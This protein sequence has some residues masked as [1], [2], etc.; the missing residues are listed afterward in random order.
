VRM[1]IGSSITVMLAV[2]S[3]LAIASVL[4]VIFSLSFSARA[5][6][7]SDDCERIKRDAQMFLDWID[8][9]NGENDRLNERIKDSQERFAKFQASHDEILDYMKGNPLFNKEEARARYLEAKRK[10]VLTQSSLRSAI[11]ANKEASRELKETLG[12]LINKLGDCGKKKAEKTSSPGAPSPPP[13]TTEAAAIDS[14]L[15]GA[16]ECTSFKEANSFV[17]GTGTGFRVT[18]KNDGTEIVDYSNMKPIASGKD[19]TTYSGTATAHISTKDGIAKIEKMESANVVMT[20]NGGGKSY[21]LP[22]LPGL[23]PGGLG[24]TKDKNSYKCT[25]DSL[26]YQ[27]SAAHDGHANTTVKLTRIKP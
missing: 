4:A 20:I 8:Q 13:S 22:K 12:D 10:F 5:Q 26:E 6:T 23:G 16:W 11:S 14:C 25:E 7:T 17:T 21:S 2:G 18:F 19:S 9:L 27:S 15:V 3:F 1:L 24:S